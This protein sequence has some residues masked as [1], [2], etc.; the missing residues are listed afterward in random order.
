MQ[1]DKNVRIM[2]MDEKLRR[3]CRYGASVITELQEALQHKV[4]NSRQHL[5]VLQ[6]KLLAAIVICDLCVQ[7]AGC[8]NWKYS[9]RARTV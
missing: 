1:N 3:M 4:A 6:Q 7:L 2:P 5:S 8:Q 9:L